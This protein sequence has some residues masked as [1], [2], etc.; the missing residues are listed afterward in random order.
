MS[1]CVSVCTCCSDWQSPWSIICK[2]Y[3]PSFSSWW[4]QST[5]TIWEGKDW[6]YMQNQCIYW[7][8]QGENEVGDHFRWFW[9][10]NSCSKAMWW[11]LLLLARAV[12]CGST[13]VSAQLDLAQ[14]LFVFGFGLFVVWLWA[15]CSFG[16]PSTRFRIGGQ[17]WAALKYYAGLP[18]IKLFT[19]WFCV[20]KNVGK[21]HHASARHGAGMG[22]AY[23]I[24]TDQTQHMN[25]QHLRF[26]PP[27]HHD[28]T[29]SISRN[30][31]PTRPRNQ[32]TSSK[33][34]MCRW[35]SRRF[36]GGTV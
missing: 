21:Q 8:Q 23:R 15:A 18:T 35:R 27:L 30:P 22:R 17:K 28:N 19:V 32:L 1:L 7:D 13:I 3:C 2:S 10:M 33:W 24:S 26:E 34:I 6:I 4:M 20:W 5:V 36:D 16:L 11:Q 14:V 9:S 12:G 25:M 29:L 31:N